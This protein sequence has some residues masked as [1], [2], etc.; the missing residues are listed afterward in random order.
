MQC[1]EMHLMLKPLHM[2]YSSKWTDC[3]RSLQSLSEG[4]K[5]T[6]FL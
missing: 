2:T 3:S 6:M 1:T 4:L 5:G